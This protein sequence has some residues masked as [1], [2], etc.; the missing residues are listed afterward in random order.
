MRRSSWRITVA[1][2]AGITGCAANAGT[3][4]IGGN[5]DGKIQMSQDYAVQ[6]EARRIKERAIRDEA[7]SKGIDDRESHGNAVR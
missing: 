6:T 5:L 3:G 1:L 2:T 4:G 7:V